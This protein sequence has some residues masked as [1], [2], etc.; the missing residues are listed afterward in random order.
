[1]VG[2]SR[3][4][5][6]YA[7]TTFGSALID[8]YFQPHPGTLG[9]IL[10]RAK[11]ELASSAATSGNRLWFDRIAGL[12][13]HSAS[14][15]NAE[16]REH[17]QLFNLLG[18]PLLRL[19]APE[20]AA[21][22]T[23]RIV[24]QGEKIQVQIESPIAGEA[25]VELIARRGTPRK[26]IIDRTQLTFND[27]DLADLQKEY[28]RANNQELDRLQQEITAGAH[29]FHLA[30]PQDFFGPAHARVYIRGRTGFALGSSDIHVERLKESK[31]TDGG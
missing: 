16:R 14:Q 3:T 6:P 5:M 28:V 15:R 26:P 25:T 13:G 4:T 8:G 27:A 22:T 29:Q 7:M 23:P 18:D 17:I 10:I 9:E 2:G 19:P 20:S 1:V 21:V 24:K 12:L 31:P 11:R 30:L